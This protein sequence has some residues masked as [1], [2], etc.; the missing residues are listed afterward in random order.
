MGNHDFFHCPKASKGFNID[1]GQNQKGSFDIDN[2]KQHKPN[3]NPQG[4]HKGHQDSTVDINDQ[5]L[6]VSMTT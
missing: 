1:L 4:L 6:L 5:A 3:T 2:H